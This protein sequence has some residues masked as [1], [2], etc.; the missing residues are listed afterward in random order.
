MRCP[1]RGLIPTRRRICTRS[2]RPSDAPGISQ[3]PDSHATAASTTGRRC[4]STMAA[5]RPWS[6][7]SA[8]RR[9]GS[10]IDLEGQLLVPGFID[11]QVNGGGGVLFNEHRTVEAIAAIGARAPALR[12][13]GLPADLISDD[14]HV[15]EQA[16]RRRA[17]RHRAGRARRARH[18][19]RRAVPEPDA[20]TRRARRQQVARARRRGRAAADHAARRRHDGDPGAGEDHAGAHPR[21]RRRRRHR[22]RRPHQ[23]HL[24]GPAA[25]A[26][27]RAARLH[28]S[29]QRHVAAGQSRAWR[30][31]RGAGTSTAGAGSSSTGITCIRRRCGSRCAPSGTT[32]S[33]WSPT[34]CRASARTPRRFQ[35]QG[36][37]ITRATATSCSTRTAA[38][39][40]ASRHGRRRAQR[41]QMLGLD[42]AGA[43]AHGQRESR[44]V[45][46]AE[47]ALGRI[48]PGCAPTC[49]ARRRVSA[50]RQ[51]WID[52]RPA[53]RATRRVARFSPAAASRPRPRIPGHWRPPPEWR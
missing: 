13:H 12:H 33:C 43:A 35:L 26:G 8:H 51:T 27:Q 45:P 32:A 2:P 4:W 3:R 46:Q 53:G 28:A 14:L 9:R 39:R 38:R 6:P 34:P 23:R 20:Q 29:V 41:R 49:R 31:R 24:R 40:R 10:A 52:G 37:R 18:P 17:R 21:A 1:A 16:H 42:L 15:V 7:R 11:T 50:S 30:R 47:C 22:L 19:H 48:A 36:T 25:G 5:S 44:R